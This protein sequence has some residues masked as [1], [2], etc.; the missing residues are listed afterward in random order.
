VITVPQGKV[1][2]PFLSPV[3]AGEAHVS[4][5]D[6]TRA[7]S[8]C[9]RCSSVC[10]GV[11]S[12]D[13]ARLTRSDALHADSTPSIFAN[14]GLHEW[15]S[16]ENSRATRSEDHHF[17]S[18][19]L[20]PCQLL[21]KLTLLSPHSEHLV[22]HCQDHHRDLRARAAHTINHDPSLFRALSPAL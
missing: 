13:A 22:V 9:K 10:S 16:R 12:M 7:R 14:D 11:P 21:C 18:V 15:T 1:S 4:S 5:V 2:D 8:S 6:V 17:E 19:L 3:T 20:V